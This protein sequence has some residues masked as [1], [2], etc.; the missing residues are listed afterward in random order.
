MTPDDLACKTVDDQFAK[1]TR[2]SIND[3]ASSR[4]EGDFSD[5]YFASSSRLLLCEPHLGIFRLSETTYRRCPFQLLHRRA[6]HCVCRCDE[7]LLNRL[8]DKHHP[9]G[10]VTGSKDVR[11]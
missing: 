6:T 8:R 2:P 5:H 3:R 1:A 11:R 10:N 7:S 4:V 9:A